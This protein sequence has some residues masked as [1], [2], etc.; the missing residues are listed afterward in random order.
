[1]GFLDFIFKL[2]KTQKETTI[3][4]IEP[5]VEQK[6]V[7]ELGLLWCPFAK[8]IPPMPLKGQY[9]KKY[10]QGAVIHF[11]A[12]FMGAIEEVNGGRKQSFLYWIIDKDGTIYQTNPL[13]E[14]G[15]HAGE[16]YWPN[17]G[18]WVSKYLLGI[19]MVCAGELKKQAD[20]S[21]KAWS[22]QKVP[23]EQVRSGE[24]K[25]N[26][27]KAG[28]YQKYTQEQEDALVRLLL[29]LKKN[30]P[31][32]FNFDYILG[33]DEVAPDRKTDPGWALSMTM[34]EFREYLKKKYQEEPNV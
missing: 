11:T 6:P 33:H 19:E 3:P 9:P 5:S 17:L 10:P 15:Y 18:S 23:P 4:P 22:G 34:P 27:L 25:N 28:S 32:I 7:E 2:F 20:G 26:I 21:F 13:N 24:K 8:T 1:M 31:D 12:G 14:W 16:S 30:N 29:W